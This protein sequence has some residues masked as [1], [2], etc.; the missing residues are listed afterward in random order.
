MFSE[1]CLYCHGKKEQA[2]SWTALF[3]KGE[4]DLLCGACKAKLMVIH[5]DICSMCS[6][7][8]DE[9][10]SKFI[11]GDRCLDC[12]RWEKDSNWSGCLDKNIALYS[13]N[14]FLKELLSRYKFRG[15]YVLAKIFAV[16]LQTK[17]KR[18][19]PD[20]IVPIPLSSERLYE[21]GFNQS[22]ALIIEVNHTP[23]HLLERIHTEKQSKKSRD[24]RIHLQQVFKITDTDTIASKKI[25]LIDDIYT[26]GSTLRHAGKILKQAGATQV[27][28]LTIAR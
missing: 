21:R 28:S 5:G 18:A 6:R 20:L 10:D 14:D 25:L 9:L 22:E 1:R 4:S 17:I 16:Q 27:Q 23:S 3:W 15:D 8:L 13:Y 11:E 26:T 12:V 19:A 24:E 2:V 7:P